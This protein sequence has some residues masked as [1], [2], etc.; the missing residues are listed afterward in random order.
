[1]DRRRRL[2]V[3]I[4]GILIVL[5]RERIEGKAFDYS[6]LKIIQYEGS[7]S[8][9]KKVKYFDEQPKIKIVFLK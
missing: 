2:A 6:K 3:L 1:M 9:W 4:A 5:V 8:M 7:Q